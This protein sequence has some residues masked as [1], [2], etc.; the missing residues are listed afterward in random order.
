ME[1]ANLIKVAIVDDNP[2]VLDAIRPYLTADNGFVL[3]GEALDGNAILEVISSQLPDLLI[4]D[5]DMPGLNGIPLV[6]KILE[7]DSKIKLLLVSGQRDPDYYSI[8]ARYNVACLTKA[9][10]T[11]KIIETAKA[12]MQGQV[13]TLPDQAMLEDNFNI[14]KADR[15]IANLGVRERD[16]LWCYVC[17]MSRSEI[18]K[19]MSVSPQVVH[20]Y[21]SALYNKLGT[22]LA[23]ILYYKDKWL[24]LLTQ[25]PVVIRDQLA[26]E[27]ETP[28]DIEQG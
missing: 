21:S 15:S 10:P 6:K 17:G 24:F 14:V 26:Q 1:H 4:F 2:M 19:A 12:L 20:N 16:L 11:T 9:T 18:A 13:L 7:V 27:A 25:Y 3:V 22:D 5:L 28:K 23:S 8:M